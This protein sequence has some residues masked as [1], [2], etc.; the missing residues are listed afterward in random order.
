MTKAPNT[1][2]IN[3][4]IIFHAQLDYLDKDSKVR[5]LRYARDWGVEVIRPIMQKVTAEIL[6]EDLENYALYWTL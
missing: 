5:G 4:R 6:A 3:N 2:A 1:M